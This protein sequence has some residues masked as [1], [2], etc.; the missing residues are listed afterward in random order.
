MQRAVSPVGA[1][2]RR[3]R[4][5]PAVPSEAVQ[6]YVVFFFLSRLSFSYVL[7][8]QTRRETVVIT[9]RGKPVAKLVPADKN[10]DGIYGFLLGKGEILGDVIQPPQLKAGGAFKVI[11]VDA[12]I[13]VRLAI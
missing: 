5:R 7:L 4:A 12:H 11:R 2:C 9:K 8:V 6:Q 10:A 1:A 13:V 3:S